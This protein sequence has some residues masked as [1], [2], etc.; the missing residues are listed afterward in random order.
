MPYIPA[1]RG[2][3][4]V[5]RVTKRSGKDTKSFGPKKLK[6]YE[7]TVDKLVQLHFDYDFLMIAVLF[8]HLKRANIRE[9]SS[10]PQIMYVARFPSCR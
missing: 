10:A 2:H 8:P 6:Y 9:E 5:I 1:F 4:S 7:C 3:E